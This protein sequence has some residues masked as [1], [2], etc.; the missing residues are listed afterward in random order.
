ML[1]THLQIERSPL[2]VGL[3]P[4]IREPRQKDRVDATEDGGSE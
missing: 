1:L 2:K 4:A 3:L